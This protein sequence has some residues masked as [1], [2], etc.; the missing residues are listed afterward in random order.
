[1]KVTQEKLPA[2]QIGLEIEITPEMTKQAYD[3]TLQKFARNANIPGFR[4][5]KV[6]RHVLVSQ[7]GKGIKVA[8]I[9]DLIDDSVKLAIE[10]EKIDAIGS[11]ELR[12]SFEDLIGQYEPG[13]PLTV[14]AV[15]DVPP[16]AKL[17]QCTGLT[18]QAEEVTYQPSKVDETLESYR[19]RLAA[20]V[21]VEGRAAQ[22]GDLAVVDFKGRLAEAPDGEEPAEIAGGSAENF[23]LELGEGKFIPGFVSGMVGMEIGE[24][25]DVD[26]TFPD[27]YQQEDLAGKAAVFTV[28]LK[29]LKEK[30]LPQIDDD[31]AQEISDFETLEELRASLE[32]RFAQEAEDKTK[33]NKQ[34]ALLGALLE[35]LE[36]DLPETLV[37]RETDHMITQTAMQFSNQGMDVKQ[38]FTP[39]IISNLRERSRPEAIARLQRTMALGEIA[40][41]QSLTVTEEEV[42]AKVEEVL[43]D[44]G[45]EPGIDRDRLV[46]VLEEELLKD[47]IFGW[48]E[49]NNTVELVPEGTLT[50]P[51]ADE[52]LDSVAAE[53]DATDGDDAAPATESAAEA[54]VDV[55]AEAV[56]DE[57]A[58]S[59]EDTA[60]T[61][62]ATRKRG[63]KGK[64]SE[65]E[66]E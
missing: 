59:T 20:Q 10:Q 28:T 58:S 50:P 60:S 12:S 56:D 32:E 21:P 17:N 13:S 34:N 11:I 15:V 49:E 6:P 53:E 37:R 29:E 35:H 51:D 66:A 55:A 41:L 14:T 38:L 33:S 65:G 48:L 57:T 26:A 1:M 39:E 18:V 24:T 3:K 64:A 62:A 42:K 2:S 52:A 4:K 47:K 30:E 19:E 25:R 61:P 45:E 40:K 5:G 8:A 7:Y 44:L 23:E 16:E 46:S 54:V 43:E 36:V 31:F 27:P 63:T 9:E 22:E